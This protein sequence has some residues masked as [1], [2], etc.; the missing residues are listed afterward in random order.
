MARRKK[1]KRGFPNQFP[2]NADGDSTTSIRIAQA[3]F[4]RIQLSATLGERLA[5]QFSGSTFDQITRSFVEGTFNLQ[6]SQ[7]EK[8]NANSEK[9][10]IFRFDLY[11]HLAGLSEVAENNPAIV[12]LLDRDYVVGP[13]IVVV[14]EARQSVVEDQVALRSGIRKRHN[15]PPLPDAVISCKWTL[16]SCR[17]QNARSEALNLMSNWKGRVPHIAIVTSEPL[18][19]RIATL[20]LGTSGIDCIYHLALPELIAGA[21]ELGL[22]DSVYLM[23]MMVDGKRLKDISALPLDLAVC[24]TN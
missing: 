17:G 22:E 10:A 7:P 9:T 21:K 8:R 5:D 2:S 15:A 24:L 16:F 11:R 23:K 4:D 1:R 13:D 14:R 6:K 19:S 3:I 18:P 20:A 12:E